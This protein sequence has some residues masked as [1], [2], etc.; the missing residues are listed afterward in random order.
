[1]ISTI[2]AAPPCSATGCPECGAG[3]PPGV[4]SRVGQSDLERLRRG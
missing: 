1:M 2:T 3:V 4:A